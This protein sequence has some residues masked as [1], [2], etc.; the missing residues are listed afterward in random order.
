MCVQSLLKVSHFLAKEHKEY[1]LYF[2]P[3]H[4]YCYDF[5]DNRISSEIPWIDV[6]KECRSLARYLDGCFLVYTS[7]YILRP[8][9][10]ELIVSN[11]KS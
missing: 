8:S 6:V 4:L 1:S 10:P 5:S 11:K 9:G 7:Y 3:I 2:H